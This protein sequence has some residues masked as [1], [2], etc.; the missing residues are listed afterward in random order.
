MSAAWCKE[1]AQGIQTSLEKF[2]TCFGGLKHSLQGVMIHL[3][4]SQVG[5]IPHQADAQLQA[6]CT[7]HVEDEIRRKEM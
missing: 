7:G 3:N 1:E 2:A 5:A 4:Q 6:L